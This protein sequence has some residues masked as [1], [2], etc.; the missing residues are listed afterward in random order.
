MISRIAA[1]GIFLLLRKLI[2]IFGKI[3]FDRI[4]MCF[5]EIDKK[6]YG[7]VNLASNK[8]HNAIIQ[9]ASERSSRVVH[10]MI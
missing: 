2:K 3:Y 8:I 4:E 6:Y 9:L 7:N 10:I 5:N 1:I